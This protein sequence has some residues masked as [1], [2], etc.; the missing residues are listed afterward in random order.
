MTDW[1]SINGCLIPSE[2]KPTALLNDRGLA[3]GQGLFETILLRDGQLPLLNRHLQRICGDA[4][5][6]GIDVRRDILALYIEQFCST[7]SE[8]KIND[9]VIK[10]IA[11]A[12]QGGR[13]YK[14]PLMPKPNLICSYAILPEDLQVQSQ[15]GIQVRCCEH[16]L[17][18][19]PTLAGIKHLNRL[20]QVIARSEWNSP[21]YAEGLMFSLDDKL[22]EAVSANIFLKDER[23]KWLTPDL[24]NAG[25]TG[26]MRS[27]LL[28]ELFPNI[29]IPVTVT[30]IDRQQLFS[31]QELFICNSIRGIIP[32]TEIF[33]TCGELQKSLPSG[34]QMRMLKAELVSNYPFYH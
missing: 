13:G 21:D 24:K 11:T 30:D 4:V 18:I 27:L 28:E 31:C 1:F 20:D 16:R 25:I 34:R 26:V 15:Q 22:I 10:V 2:E 7:L 6:L 29:G 23:G 19:N 3:Y 14:S 32:V 33:S 8:N 12:G 9:G 5:T 17:P